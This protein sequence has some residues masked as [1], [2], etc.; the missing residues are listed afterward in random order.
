MQGRANGMFRATADVEQEVMRGEIEAF[1]E[2]L[3]SCS[4]CA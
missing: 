2:A 4:C 3:H 1:G